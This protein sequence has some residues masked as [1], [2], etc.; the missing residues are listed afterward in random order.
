MMP[1]ESICVSAGDVW[2]QALKGAWNKA[3]RKRGLSPRFL[4]L[5]DSS[6]KNIID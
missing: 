5:S 6:H 1:M 3:N 4:F 2:R